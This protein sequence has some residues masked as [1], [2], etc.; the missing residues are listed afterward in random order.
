M[1]EARRR[2]SEFVEREIAFGAFRL[3]PSKQLLLEGERPVGIGGRALDL[4]T[5]LV[6]RAGEL[7]TKE[8]LFAAAWPG[9]A[10]EE[11][12]LRAQM[13]ALR[14]A[15]R[16]GRDGARY[17]ATVPG[18]G[19]RFV[20]PVSRREAEPTP[21]SGAPAVPERPLRLA[22]MVGRDDVV[23][24]IRGR[25]ERRRFVTI[26]GPG[27]IGK[28][29]VALA[30][31][32]AA[33]DAYADGV[34]FADLASVSD[35]S[36]VPSAF[37]GALGRS[38][39][40]D[41]P[42][43]AAIA[44]LRER[45][46]LIVLDTCEHVI[47]AAAL[48]AE[49]VL[50]GAPGT[51]LLATSREPLRAEGEGVLRLL[52]LDAPPSAVGLGAAEAMSFSAVQLFVDRVGACLDGYELSDADAAAAAEICRRLDGIPLAIELVAGRVDAFG[53]QGIAA[54]L[55]DRFRL[56]TSGR[57]TALPRHQ[58]LRA[59]LDWSY[60]LL[61]DD[62][63]AL[64][65]R[66]AVF[67]S[68]FT[69]RSAGAVAAGA[70]LSEAAIAG[71][72]ANLVAKSLVVA[73]LRDAS[74]SYCLLDTTRAYAREKLLESGDFD[75]TE[76]RHAELFL[77]L[78]GRDAPLEE[79]SLA[80]LVAARDD[81]HSSLDWAFS[82]GGDPGLGV[83]LTVASLPMGMG[84]SMVREC[85]VR[86]E[87][88][89]ASLDDDGESPQER[90]K[91]L[92]ALGVHL[93]QTRSAPDKTRA[94]WE[95]SLGLAEQQGDVD[96]QLRALFG[97]WAQD[98]V[99]SDL[100]GARATAR[101]FQRVA[102]RC[103]DP[104]DAAVGDRMIGVVLYI[105]GDFDG[106]RRHLEAMLDRYPV[107][108]RRSD[109]FRFALDQ[110]AGA[111]NLLASILWIQG[112][113]DQATAMAL[114]SLEEA[115]ATGHALT[116]CSTLTD[117]VCPQAFLTGDLGA[118]ER[119]A[120]MLGEHAQS[121]ALDV[122]I[123]WAR[124]FH[125]V[126][127]GRRGDPASIAGELRRALDGI[128]AEELHPRY[129]TL[130]ASL[131]DSLGRAGDPAHAR[132]A[133]ERAHERCEASGQGWCVAELLR[134]EGELARLGGDVRVAEDRMRDSLERARSQGALAWELRSATS[135]ARLWQ[136]QGRPARA[137]ELLA[138]VVERFAEGFS[139]SDFSDA[140]QLIDA[141]A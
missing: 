45:R 8:E 87:R 67:E 80:E 116:V 140:R 137:R 121:H 39:A 5:A 55:G 105:E 76:R 73:D 7:M 71:L 132:A 31:A 75:A 96:H 50:R 136:Q 97:I 124:H 115:L 64:L 126:L 40:Y 53:V 51:H 41:D 1:A 21:A 84:L 3:L 61:P 108:G 81:V 34:F 56:L 4:L 107:A 94:T 60:E 74:G 112:F 101:R 85:R 82:E 114:A 58:T 141:L 35:A 17:V 57:R 15:L 92:A 28:T 43:P 63:R 9:L 134:V 37:A 44:W 27:G 12:N 32:D 103:D 79:R 128:S 135:L 30:V 42:T 22:P 104:L 133:I 24:S 123:A 69:L 130:L 46:A 102:A 90:M 52:P 86:V 113:A 72:V 19:Y 131:A 16:D 54:Q 65:R 100:R 138:P 139:T 91:L 111:R 59:A 95:R 11:S 29:T 119:Y 127:L 13:S 62:E 68:G 117:I 70:C 38:I 47:E 110:R 118:A 120:A 93:M 48:L 122:G 25:L 106:A 88:A 20:L 6:D 18:R 36:L 83:S 66:L 99:E 89:L 125:T 23:A 129:A 2:P 33:A 98:F 26:V 10:V 49:R 77:E 14:K 78:C 109:L